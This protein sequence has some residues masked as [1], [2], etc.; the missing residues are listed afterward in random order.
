MVRLFWCSE[1]K[2]SKIFGTS[3]KV[4]HDFQREM[5]L[6]FAISTSSKPYSN[7]NANHLSFSRGCANGTR[8]FWSEFFSLGIFAYHLYKPSTN[9]FSHVNGKQPGFQVRRP[10]LS[11]TPPQCFVT[12]RSQ[13]SW[14]S[15]PVEAAS[16][17]LRRWLQLV[18]SLPLFVRLILMAADPYDCSFLLHNTE[19]C[20]TQ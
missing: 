13:I 4:V 17:V 15:R 6:P 11:A 5:R 14:G 7:L 19:R 1:R 10:N 3:W 12:L 8:Q 16:S 20:R 18:M 9:R 2:I